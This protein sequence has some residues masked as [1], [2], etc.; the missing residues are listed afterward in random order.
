MSSYIDKTMSLN[1]FPPLNTCGQFPPIPLIL[2]E[3]GG[4][5]EASLNAVG[6]TIISSNV[7]ISL[8]GSLLVFFPLL[9]CI[10]T[11][12]RQSQPFNHTPK[13]YAMK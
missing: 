5:K 6:K 3:V 4:W 2:L 13:T 12:K 11:S 9:V 7:H 10:S 8:K 1:S